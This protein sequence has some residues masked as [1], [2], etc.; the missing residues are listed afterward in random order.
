M[1]ASQMANIYVNHTGSSTPPYDTEAKAARNI[2]VALDA[3]VSG[4]TVLI[5]ADQDYVMNG[6]DQQ[7]A[8]FDVDVNDNVTIRSY[9]STVGD[10]DYGGVYYKDSNYGWAVIDANGGA[11][12]VFSAGTKNKLRWYNLKTINVNTSYISF[13]I[14]PTVIKNG[15]VV[16]NC[17]ITGG[18]KAIY[19][20]SLRDL[21]IRDCRFTGVY[22]SAS[23]QAVVYT[24][25]TA[26]GVIV[27]SCEFNHGNVLNSITFGGYGCRVCDNIFN[28]EGSVTSVIDIVGGTLIS[29]NVIYNGGS[30]TITNGINAQSNASGSSIFDNI[31]AGC[32][33][34]INDLATINFGGW[35]CFYNNG[36]NWTLHTGD[37]MADPQFMNVANGDFRLKPTSPCL[38][39]GKPVLGGNLQAYNG[40]TTM[41]VWQ[42]K[43][44][45]RWK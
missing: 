11:F 22:S 29:N 43:S 3:A 6:T 16:Q 4:D 18:Q 33:T 32:T 10:Q 21:M 31:I 5:K 19:G 42:R 37:I 7:A 25:V 13:Y 23:S 45:L 17:W 14:A 40:Y 39:T 38:N 24:T 30:G 8:Q 1:K 26:T 28:I 15:C 35:N 27:V 2:Q 44:L 12:H 36:A 20:N 9:Y 34:S 41:G